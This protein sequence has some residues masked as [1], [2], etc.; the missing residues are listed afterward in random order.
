MTTANATARRI[1]RIDQAARRE[2]LDSPE[3]IQET[4]AARGGGSGGRSVRRAKISS[5]GTSTVTAPLL[6]ADGNPT[7]DSV[8]VYCWPDKGTTDISGAYPQLSEN[9]T[10]VVFEDVD[11]N[12]YLIS[13]SLLILTG[14]EIE[15]VTDLQYN[16][17]SHAFQKKTRTV[18]VLDGGTESGWSNWEVCQAVEV[19]TDVEFSSYNIVHDYANIYLPEGTSGGGTDTVVETTTC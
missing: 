2:R 19:V 3:I 12:Y 11:S 15:V 17:S 5:V 4:T 14:E 10:I 13:P 7:G 16:S 9:D 6:D 1:Q 18:S 8:T